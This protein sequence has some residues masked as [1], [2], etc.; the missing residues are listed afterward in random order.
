LIDANKTVN[1]CTGN[2][3][4]V[5]HETKT[6]DCTDPKIADINNTESCKDNCWDKVIRD[7]RKTTDFMKNSFVS[8]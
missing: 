3:E 4:S 2:L 6:A 7:A 1:G 5:R 8:H